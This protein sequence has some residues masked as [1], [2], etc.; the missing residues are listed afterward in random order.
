[1]ECNYKFQFAGPPRRLLQPSASPAGW[2]HPA[3]RL[4]VNLCPRGGYTKSK[5][6]ISNSTLQ[7]RLPH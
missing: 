1:M 4:I 2:G 7:L 3:L 5:L 6:L